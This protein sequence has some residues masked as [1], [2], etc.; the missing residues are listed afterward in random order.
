MFRVVA[1][2]FAQILIFALTC[3][4][5]AQDSTQLQV[6]RPYGVPEATLPCSPEEQAWWKEL[7]AAGSDLLATHRP[8]DKYKERFLTALHDGL[9][10]SYSPPIADVRPVILYKTEPQYTERARQRQINGTITL[11]LELLPDGRVGEVTVID[12]L[13]SGLDENAAAAARQTIFLPAVKDRK[14]VRASVRIVMTF[15][16]Y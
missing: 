2:C 8:K 5:D 7:R 13:G 4:A 12:S 11:Q 6:R 16:L 15:N 1:V 3:V 10:K 14:F 9:T